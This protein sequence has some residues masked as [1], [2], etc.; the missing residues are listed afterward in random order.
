MASEFAQHWTIDPAVEFLNHGS[1]GAAPRVV[2]A[3]QQAWRD[4]MERDT[5]RF[6]AR[7]LESALDQARDELA[8]FLLADPRDLAFVPNATAGLNAVLRSLAFEPGDELLTTDHAYNAARTTLEHVAERSGA[9]VVVARVPFPLA[10]A[11]HVVEAMLAAATPR[12]RLA[13]ID[14]ITSPTAL[15]FPVDRMVAALAQRGIDTLVDGAHAPGQVALEVPAV[16]AAYYTGNL[17]KWVCA[18]KG[19]AFLWIRPDRQA[20]VRPLAISHGANS[21]RAD[22]SRFLLEFDWTGTADPTAYLAIPAA[23]QFGASL[24]PGGWDA[25]RLR[26][27]SVALAARDLLCQALGVAPPAP[28]GLVGC[29]ASVA[30]PRIEQAGTVQGIEL[31]NDPVHEALLDAGLQVMVTPWPQR[32]EGGP[33][34]RLIRIS[35]AAHNDL[36]QYERLADVLRSIPEARAAA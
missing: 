24:L 9:K 35:V 27:R 8:A 10:S 34:Q 12:T 26:N 7:D 4:Q 29:M 19:A 33:W 22:K 25:L 31:Y 36:A 30:L 11:E 32:P 17:H 23:L 18:P 28:D 3:A 20:G 14:H 13:I 16:G 21:P 1:F 6:F 5:T 15:V 2:Q